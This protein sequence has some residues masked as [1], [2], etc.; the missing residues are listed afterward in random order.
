MNKYII[1]RRAIIY[2]VPS[3]WLSVSAEVCPRTQSSDK[4][5]IWS[6]ERAP[7]EE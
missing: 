2:Y 4:D 1:T 6:N 3:L 5:R 7:L